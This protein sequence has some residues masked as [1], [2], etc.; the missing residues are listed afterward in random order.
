MFLRLQLLA[1]DY[2][3]Q[4]VM[5][6]LF[7]WYIWLCSDCL[8]RSLVGF[9]PY[10]GWIFAVLL[11]SVQCFLF[12]CCFMLQLCIDPEFYNLLC[13]VEPWALCFGLFAMCCYYL[14]HFQLVDIK[15][16]LVNAIAISQ[17]SFCICD[18]PRLC[19]LSYICSFIL[20]SIVLAHLFIWFTSLCTTVALVVSFAYWFS[21][22]CSSY[23]VVPWFS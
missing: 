3:D 19:I 21:F 11:E 13:G 17:F 8:T 10:I 20:E 23:S 6:P 7:W 22:L 14:H 15:F 9:G 1:N 18:W 12:Q 16:V 5:F 4:T 2:A